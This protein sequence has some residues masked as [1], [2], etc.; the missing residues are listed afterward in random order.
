MVAGVILILLAGPTLVAFLL[1][2]WPR[3]DKPAWQP[4]RYDDWTL[5]RR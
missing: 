1:D 4:V 2:R 5:P 3:H